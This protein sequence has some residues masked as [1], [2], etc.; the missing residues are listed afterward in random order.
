MKYFI[1]NYTIKNNRLFSNLFIN[2]CK[3]STFVPKKVEYKFIDE[4]EKIMK[5]SEIENDKYMETVNKYDSIYK[6]QFVKNNN[7]IIKECISIMDK[8]EISECDD[9]ADELLTFSNKELNLFKIAIKE[10]SDKSIGIDTSILNECYPFISDNLLNIFP[11]DNPNWSKLSN[12]EFGSGANAKSEL[13]P[14]D[15]PKKEEKKVE[16]PKVVRF[17]YIKRKHMLM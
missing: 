7:E 12:V 1:K 10:I 17:Y 9:L 13:K 5:N 14:E 3:F 6:E 8:D 15:L 4:L 16:E 2:K 11:I